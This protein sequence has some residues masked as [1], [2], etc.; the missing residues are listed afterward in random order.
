MRISSRKGGSI[1]AI[2]LTLC[3]TQLH[4]KDDTIQTNNTTTN[5]IRTDN[6]VLQF[7]R[8]V[9]GEDG[10]RFAK[11][12]VVA[13]SIELQEKATKIRKMM[14]QMGNDKKTKAPQTL[15]EAITFLKYISLARS[16]TVC[17]EYEGVYYFSGGNSAKTIK[18]FSSGFAIRKGEPKIYTWSASDNGQTGT[19]PV[20]GKTNDLG[21]ARN[22]GKP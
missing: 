12:K 17:S 5:I 6:D 2:M 7:I 21:T 22:D 10:D 8:K 15:D 9:T 16:P 1:A 20:S 19:N 4:A 11:P 3:L 14:R 13:P 18:D